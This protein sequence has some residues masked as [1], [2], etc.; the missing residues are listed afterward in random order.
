MIWWIVPWL[1]FLAC[2]AAV[3]IAYLLWRHRHEATPLSGV[4]RHDLQ[5]P[6]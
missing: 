1:L 3:G 6:R 5:E 2:L 4:S